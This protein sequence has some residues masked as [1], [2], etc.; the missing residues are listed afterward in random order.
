MQ[1]RN[2]TPFPFGAKACSRRPPQPEAV[3]IVRG[4]F[5]LRLGEPLA[6]LEGQ[7]AQGALTAET[8]EGADG[9][10]DGECTYPGDFADWKPAA[11]LL[12]RGACHPPPGDPPREHPVGFAVAGWSKSLLVPAP[13]EGRQVPAP[14]GPIHPDSPDRR[15]MLGKEYGPSYRKARAPWYAEDFDWAYFQA[16]PPDQRLAGHLRGDEE[17]TLLNLHPAAQTASFR[18][19]GLRIRAVV[20][21]TQGRVQDARMSLD[22]LLVEPDAGLVTLTWRGHAEVAEDDLTDVR[23]VVIA[24]EPLDAAPLPLDR[25]REELARLAR[26]PRGLEDLPPEVREAYDLVRDGAPRPPPPAADG[27]DPVSKLLAERLGGLHAPEQ[28][29]VRQLV[30]KL[31]ALRTPEGVDLERTLAQALARLPAQRQAAYLPATPAGTPRVPMGGALAALVERVAKLR[32]DAAARGTKLEGVERLDALLAD[33]RLREII[34]GYHPPG[35][36]AAPPPAPGPGVDLSGQ[37]LSGQDLSGRDLSGAKLSGALLSGANLSGASLS[38]ADLSRAVLFEANLSGADLSGADLSQA[39]LGGARAS[40]ADLRGAVLD[41]TIFTRADLSGARL[42]GAHGRGALLDEADL[43][44]IDGEG[45]RLEG[46]VLQA[47]KLDRASLRR[48]ELVACMCAGSSAKAADLTGASLP[49]TS[50]S[51]ADL[52]GAT[53]MD[54]RGEGAALLRAK[55]D[56]ADL[57]YASLPRAHLSW[58]SARGARLACAVLREARFYR[59]SLERADLAQADLFGADLRKA[60]LDGASFAGASLYGAQLD[61]ASV[62][63]CDLAGANLR[64]SGLE[65]A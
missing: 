40:A 59:A 31:R 19:P 20:E 42:A 54:A 7:L 6:P 14:F 57:R 48:A 64:R 8:F 11:D 33:T 34:P 13:R 18:L 47:A 12:L 45:L 25:Y 63:G 2:L 29:R 16:A 58:A 37:D 50:F 36:A 21:D 41:Q 55:L 56:G 10:R 43:R 30:A 26:D 39:N 35:E 61:V 17:V 62:A 52:E 51:D 38:G 28:D 23:A 65:R 5:S 24:A 32:Q 60:R 1:T 15:R 3:L 49:R 22:T 44:D 53:L 27:A 4:R 46:A 9:A